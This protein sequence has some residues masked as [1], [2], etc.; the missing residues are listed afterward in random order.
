MARN[1]RKRSF[2]LDEET[3]DRLKAESEKL[4]L[5]KSSYLRAVLSKLWS[6]GGPLLMALPSGLPPLRRDRRGEGFAGIIVVVLISSILIFGLIVGAILFFPSIQTWTHRVS[7]CGIR[8][9]ITAAGNGTT[10]PLAGM[11]VSVGTAQHNFY[12]KT[13]AMGFY[14]VDVTPDCGLSTA[15]LL[16]TSPLGGGGQTGGCVINTPPGGHW[17]R[18]NIRVPSPG[19]YLPPLLDG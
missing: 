17:Y 5:S 15:N 2:A 13:D 11:S 7:G 18:L 16:A 8:G 10:I 4:K 19:C 9:T 6:S 14:S 1:V 12:G 3:D